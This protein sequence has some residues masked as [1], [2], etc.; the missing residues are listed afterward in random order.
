MRNSLILKL[1]R[2]DLQKVYTRAA[3]YPSISTKLI[4]DLINTEYFYDLT[5]GHVK[6]L[7]SI[8]DKKI[9]EIFPGK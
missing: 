5:Y 3:E 7:E 6:D 9:I 1:D 8:L 4:K 2:E